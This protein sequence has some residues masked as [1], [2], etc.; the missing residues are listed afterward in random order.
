MEGVET[1]ADKHLESPTW[2]SASRADRETQ[3]TESS[4]DLPNFNLF[5]LGQIEY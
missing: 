2:A 4:I 1:E 5:Y 3:V